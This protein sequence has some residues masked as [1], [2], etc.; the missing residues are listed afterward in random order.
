[1][2]TAKADE[3]AY[4]LYLRKREDARISDA[5]DEQRIMNVAIVEPPVAPALP[6][7]SIVFYM[8]LALGVSGFF[9][10][11][12]AF[13]ADYFDSTVRTPGEAQRLLEVPV[14]AWLPAPHAEATGILAWPA[15]APRIVP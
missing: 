3:D 15:R 8:G 1:M 11:G 7:H 5:L 2:R 14:L 6:N 12:V 10:V 13:T 4:L 9:A